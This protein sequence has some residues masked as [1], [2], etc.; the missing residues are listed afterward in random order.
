MKKGTSLSGL[1]R[2][3]TVPVA[4][5]FGDKIIKKVPRSST[6]TYE[7]TS[8]DWPLLRQTWINEDD[9]ALEDRHH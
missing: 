2:R 4:V 6:S 7:G 1:S 3:C 8:A 5:M 9:I